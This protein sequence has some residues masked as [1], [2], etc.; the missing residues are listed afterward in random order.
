MCYNFA[1]YKHVCHILLEA[2]GFCTS[3]IFDDDTCMAYADLR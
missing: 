3:G 1:S 2:E